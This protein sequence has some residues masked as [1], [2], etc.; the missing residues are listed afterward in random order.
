VSEV[1]A[2][3]RMAGPQLNS[4]V[5]SRG[6]MWVADELHPEDQEDAGD[7]LEIEMEV[8]EEGTVDENEVKGE[9]MEACT[10]ADEWEKWEEE[11][12]EEADFYEEGEEKEIEMNVMGWEM[13]ESEEDCVNKVEKDD[14]IKNEVKKKYHTCTE[15]D[16][17]FA[18]TETLYNHMRAKHNHPKLQ[19]QE[20]EC[21][22]AF[23]SSS[24][25]YAHQKAVHLG[26]KP[27]T[28]S[29]CGEGGMTFGRKEHLENHGRA[30]HG[31]PKLQCSEKGCSKLFNFRSALNNHIRG[32]H[33]G[34]QLKNAVC[35]DPGCGKRFFARRCLE[36]HMKAKHGH[37]KVCCLEP[38]CDKLFSSKKYMAKHMKLKHEGVQPKS[39]ECLEPGCDKIARSKSYL[40]VH[41]RS[42]H[43]HKKIR[44]L[45]PT[46]EKLFN[47]KKYMATHMKMKHQGVQ[48]KNVPRARM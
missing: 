16:G 22:A 10:K 37:D 14:V 18:R 6:Q 24:N 8:E 2:V 23:T 45:E 34:V 31:H 3:G 21:I 40:E 41:M 43:G 28:C 48:P 19:C 42:K 29:E 15:C 35:Q 20:K 26:L 17:T 7:Y 4:M 36:E 32:V 12:E 46:C 9:V 25:L 1:E 38:T 13:E 11:E 5:A 27:Y 47:S 39:F 44:C 33:R 30:K